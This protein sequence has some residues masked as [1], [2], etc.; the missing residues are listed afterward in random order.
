MTSSL[1]YVM[2]LQ[3]GTNSTLKPIIL[4][5]ILQ[6][7][8]ARVREVI[9]REVVMPKEHLNEYENYRTLITKQVR[10]NCRVIDL[11]V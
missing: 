6:E 11:F 7:A 4:D 1:N 5:E 3:S 2:V 8:K 10:K 9:S